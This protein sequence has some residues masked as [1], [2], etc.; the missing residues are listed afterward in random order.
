[1]ATDPASPLGYGMLATYCTVSLP[2]PDGSTRIVTTVQPTFGIATDPRT[3]QVLPS[4]A[5]GRQLLAGAMVCRLSTERNTLPDVYIP[6]TTAQYGLDLLD[7]ADADMTADEVGQ[8]SASVDAQLQMDERIVTSTTF[9]VLASD[10]LLVPITARDGQGPFKL[11]LAI[12]TLNQNLSV[13][14]SP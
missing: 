14:A 9:S 11:T 8:L 7:N 1:M 12:D 3:G 10:T 6:T 5:S 13:L 4:Y 2:M